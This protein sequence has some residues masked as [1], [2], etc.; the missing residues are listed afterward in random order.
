ML[1]IV[2]PLYVSSNIHFVV[3]TIN[4]IFSP[5][6]NSLQ[7]CSQCPKTWML[8]RWCLRVF[9]LRTP[10]VKNTTWL[11]ITAHSRK[12][13][14]ESHP[15]VF[16]VPSFVGA[17]T[18]STRIPKLGTQLTWPLMVSSHTGKYSKRST[19]FCKRIVCDSGKRL[20]VLGLF[21]NTSSNR[22]L[23][24]EKYDHVSMNVVE[25]VNVNIL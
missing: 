10:N 14:E 21:N 24:D 12:T 13:L 5:T 2:Q 3:L 4:C 9:C 11:P 23:T 7:F 19:T 6:V 8:V 20:L 16:S 25:E 18:A 1:P 15:A 17:D 22:L